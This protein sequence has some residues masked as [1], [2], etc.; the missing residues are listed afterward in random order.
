M[1]LPAV[2]APRPDVS[3]VF[4]TDP[5]LGVSTRRAVLERAVAEDLVVAGTHLSFPG[6]SHVAR[7]GDGFVIQPEPWCLLA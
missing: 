4:D 1:S 3:L 7:A 5:Q 6:F 2:Q